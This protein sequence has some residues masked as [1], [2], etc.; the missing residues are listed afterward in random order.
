MERVLGAD[1][2]IYCS[3]RRGVGNLG[4]FIACGGHGLNGSREKERVY[5]LLQQVHCYS[6]NKTQWAHHI[7]RQK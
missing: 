2:V 6:E 5:A 4:P 1:R 3:D 7:H